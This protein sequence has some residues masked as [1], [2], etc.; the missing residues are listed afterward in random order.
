MT[1]TELN[2][3]R[4]IPCILK[5]D[6]DY[7][8]QLH[9]LHNEYP[10]APENINF[11]VGDNKINVKNCRLHDTQRNF[12]V[13]WNFRLKITKNHRGIKLEQKRWLEKYINLNIKLGTAAKTAL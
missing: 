2:N 1:E 11:K 10:L 8:D 5:A 13:V 12:K 4:N 7:P 3:W 9:G 6:L